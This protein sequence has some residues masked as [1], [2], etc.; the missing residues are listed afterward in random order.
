VFSVPIRTAV[1]DPRTHT[2]VYGVGGGITWSSEPEAEDD[3]VR[4]KSWILGRSRRRFDLVE[5]MRHD[6]DGIAYR[7]RHLDRLLD[8]AEW[9]GIPADREHI[10]A[11]LDALEPV[12]HTHRL[13]LLIDQ[14]GKARTETEVRTPLPEPALLAID[15]VVTRSDDPFCCHKTTF[16]RHYDEAVRRHPQAHDVILV[17]E[18]G[19]V[20]ETTRA[21]L[22]Y[23]LNGVWFVPPLEDGGL[24][25]IGRAVALAEGQVRERSIAAKDLPACDAV[26]LISAVRGWRPAHL[27]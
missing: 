7:D 9:F 20:I 18:Y 27:P 23:R 11:V 2:Y 4:A 12:E 14:V 25:G 15:D 13:R 17:N 22:A 21:N 19:N 8:S 10:D 24:P 3:E 1:I 5:T 16:R 26:A 6:P